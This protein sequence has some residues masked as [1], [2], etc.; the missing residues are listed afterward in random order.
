MKQ[1][2]NPFPYSRKKRTTEHGGVLALTSRKVKRPLNIRKPVHLVLRSDL[3][4]GKRSLFRN[5]R[6]VLSLLRRYSKM[7]GVRVYE[8]AVC[9]NHIHCCVRG[10]DRVRLQHFFRVFAGQVAQ[11]ILRMYPLQKGEAKAFR[12]GTH[13]KSEK[14]FW[15]LLAYTRV[16]GWGRDFANVKAYIFKNT[17]ETLGLIT[18]V[19]TARRIFSG[20][21][22]T[23]GIRR[24]P[25]EPERK[26][27]G[28]YELVALH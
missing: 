12:G 14:S 21:P 2:K 8:T 5:K 28:K 4:K 1:K 9:G 25:E 18:Y 23:C 7:F 22:D 6:L 19:R 17:L 20:I 26:T 11:E 15:S 3:A 27:A 13:P 24:S 10:D 16:V